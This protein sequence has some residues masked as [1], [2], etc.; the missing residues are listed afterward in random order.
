M[1]LFQENHSHKR[2]LPLEI[3]DTFKNFSHSQPSGK[4]YDSKIIDTTNTTTLGDEETGECIICFE[5]ESNT[6]IISCGHQCLCNICAKELVFKECP[7]CRTSI[8]EDGIIKV[9]KC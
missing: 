5:N 2:Y 1:V 3:E 8:P 7:I 4:D 6:V 9:F